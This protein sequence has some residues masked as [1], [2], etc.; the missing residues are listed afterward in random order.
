MIRNE[1]VRTGLKIIVGVSILVFAFLGGAYIYR[2][3]TA[4]GSS[5]ETYK[6]IIAESEERVQ[7]LEKKNTQLRDEIFAQG[8]ELTD[9]ISEN[10][11]LEDDALDISLN[12]IPVDDDAVQDNVRFIVAGHLYGA[13]SE[14]TPIVP[15]QTLIDFV[16]ELN[17]LSPNLFVALG[18]LAQYPSEESYQ[19]LHQNFL[20]KVK[21]PVLNA[22]GNHDFDNGRVFYQN[23]FG[24]TFYFLKYVQSQLIILDT[25]VANCFI[26]GNQ[27]EI[28]EKAVDIALGDD[29]IQNIFVFFHRTLFLDESLQLREKPN[30]ACRFG[31]NYTDLQNETFIPAAQIKPVY[32]I[33]GD[34]G[35]FDGNLSPFYNKYPDVDLYTLAVGLGDSSNDV[36]LQIDIHSNEVDFVLIPIGGNSFLP[37]ESYT[38][39]Y[40]AAP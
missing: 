25:E 24:Q 15:A 20:D 11:A 37:I 23:E 16:P 29:D 1:N 27:R 7:S 2:L 6:A 26:V 3:R 30:G 13:H 34:V 9:I 14:D 10:Y 40:W 18:D 19:A 36:L 8:V 12:D 33:A 38:P 17:K 22:P 4:L 21:A 35:A 5:T 28:L 32:L 39:E 31:S